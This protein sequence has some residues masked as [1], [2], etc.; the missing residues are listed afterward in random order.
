MIYISS[1]NYILMFS[2]VLPYSLLPLLVYLSFFLLEWLILL[3]LENLLLFMAR[4][5]TTNCSWWSGFSVSFPIFPCF[6]SFYWNCFVFTLSLL[7]YYSHSL[8][9]SFLFTFRDI[10]SVN[11]LLTPSSLC[12][13]FLLLLLLLL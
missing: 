7:L 5:L 6:L 12:S 10:S 3:M 9:S 13:W 8:S 4:L 11:V 1:L 2:S